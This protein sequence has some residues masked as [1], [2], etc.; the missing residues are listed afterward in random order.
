MGKFY[1]IDPETCSIDELKSVIDAVDAKVEYFNT[2]Q[3]GSKLFINSVYGV[4]GTAFFNLFNDLS[5]TVS[6][7]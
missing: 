1:D 2:L 6:S 4:F 7:W 3:L 5:K